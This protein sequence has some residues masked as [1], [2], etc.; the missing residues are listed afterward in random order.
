M[1]KI[2]Y[3]KYL[4]SLLSKMTSYPTFKAAITT[5]F[6]SWN[7]LQFAV[8]QQAGGPQSKEIA[9]WMIGV[10]EQYFY[11]NEDIDAEEIA[12]DLAT[13]LDQELNTIVDDESDLQIGEFLCRMYQM[14]LAGK[15]SDVKEE[16]MKMP[17]P[18]L[19][20]CR[21]QD[22]T[23]DREEENEC[24]NLVSEQMKTLQLS[25]SSSGSSL[26]TAPEAERELTE[27]EKQQLQDEADGWTVIKKTNK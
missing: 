26:L 22:D 6:N 7:A 5:G 27:E 20:N 1:G 17:K 4:G 9:Q 13:I 8:Q 2:I 25:D 23:S 18:D 3:S 12:E 21:L 24:P 10:T 14:C 11:D 15:D 19:S 16:L